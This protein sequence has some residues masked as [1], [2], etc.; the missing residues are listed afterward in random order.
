MFKFKRTRK[1]VKGAVGTKEIAS[2]QKA[3]FSTISGL[4]RHKKG[5]V[6][7]EYEQLAEHGITEEQIQ[8]AMKGLKRMYRMLLSFAGLIVC[9]TLWLLYIE[10]YLI[11]FAASSVVFA[12]L[13]NAFKFH[14]WSVQLKMKKLGIS[15]RCWL[16]YTVSN[17]LGDKK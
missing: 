15:F 3:I 1:L 7:M 12:I 8:M 6:K 4:Y 5:H 9:Y 2:Q 10:S 11:A 17:V 14:F 13:A 16:K